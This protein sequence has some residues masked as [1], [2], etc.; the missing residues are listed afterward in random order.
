MSALRRNRGSSNAFL[1]IYNG[2]K[3]EQ[4]QVEGGINGEKETTGIVFQWFRASCFVSENSTRNHW[5]G[6][7]EIAILNELGREG[8]RE[9][10]RERERE[11]G[12]YYLW[13]C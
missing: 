3:R 9:R 7:D 5:P 12:G 8:G 13:C 6:V 10:E 11:N 4:H 2:E 1:P